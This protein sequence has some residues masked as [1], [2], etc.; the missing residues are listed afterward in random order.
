MLR[1]TASRV[2]IEL[3]APEECY[4]ADKRRVAM[5]V[6]LFGLTMEAPS[7]T[8]Y[9]WSPWRCAAI[10]HKLYESL[11]AVPTRARSSPGRNPHAHQRAESVESGG[12]RIFR[13]C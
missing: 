1:L 6:E 3:D 7:V 4:A 11:K 9:L 10:E 12:L 8:F 2:V 5:R 13:A